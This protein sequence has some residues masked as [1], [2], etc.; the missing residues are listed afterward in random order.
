MYVLIALL[1][2]F[3]RVEEKRKTY[4]CRKKRDVCCIAGRPRPSDKYAV[5]FLDSSIALKNTNKTKQNAT[6]SLLF[7]HLNSHSYFKAVTCSRWK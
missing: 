7:L 1:K 6:P 4:R 3:Q 5:C 2:V